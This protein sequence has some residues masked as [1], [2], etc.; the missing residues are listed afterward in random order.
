MKK[1]SA[2]LSFICLAMAALTGFP[3][4]AS[5]AEPIRLGAIFG[6]TGLMAPIAE[7]SVQGLKLAFEQ[8]LPKEIGGRPVEVIYE[9][10]SSKAD[11]AVQKAKKLVAL[12][13]VG[14]GEF[15]GNGSPQ[16]VPNSIP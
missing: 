6:I 4:W 13:E 1:R 12:A 5:G 14:P 15:V 7:E 9:D 2:L 10:S 8:F 11:L 3:M 16:E